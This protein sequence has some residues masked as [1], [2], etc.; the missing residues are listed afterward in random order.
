MKNLYLAALHT[1]KL[2]TEIRNELLPGKY[3]IA[4]NQQINGIVQIGHDSERIP[5][6]NLLGKRVLALCLHYMGCQDKNVN[7][8][9][10]KILDDAINGSKETLNLLE[11]D[12]RITA[13]LDR[14]QKKLVTCEKVKT[15]GQ[16]RAKLNIITTDM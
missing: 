12:P 8:I 5:T 1:I 11:N 9:L 13:A 4:F 7:A 10:D 16:V 3:P 14:L 2:D 6:S 15:K